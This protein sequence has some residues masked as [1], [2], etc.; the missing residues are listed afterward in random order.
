MKITIFIFLV[1]SFSNAFAE[2]SKDS[3]NELIV[4][5]QIDKTTQMVFASIIENLN[6]NLETYK[7]DYL[8]KNKTNSSQKILLVKRVADIKKIIKDDLSWESQAPM[9][10]RVYSETLTEDEVSG[11]IAFYK[12]P[13][14][15][16]W[17]KKTPLIF[18]KAK[19][20]GEALMMSTGQKIQDTIKTLETDLAKLAI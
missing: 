8:A 10:V 12:S 15:Q 20:E 7:T 2:A 11:I 14:G 9:Y 5:A 19:Q 4:I 3:V 16:A 18:E 1:I 6:T 13:A 17:I